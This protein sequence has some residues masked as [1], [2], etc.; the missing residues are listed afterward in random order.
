MENGEFLRTRRPAWIS[1]LNSPFSILNSFQ[2]HRR[3]GCGSI[4][5]R[6]DHVFALVAED[7]ESFVED[8]SQL[9]E[10]RAATNATTFVVLDLWLR[11][12]HPVHFPVDVAQ[13][14]LA[15]SSSV[16]NR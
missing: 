13:A 11:D 8:R 3:V 14:A 15:K 16:T 2:T 1:I 12:A 6:G 4:L 10:D 5:W 7:F 9:G